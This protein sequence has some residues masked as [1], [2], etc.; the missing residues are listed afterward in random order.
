MLASRLCLAALCSA[1]TVASEARAD[2]EGDLVMKREG[3]HG[4]RMPTGKIRFKDGKL[5]TEIAMGPMN[6]TTLVDFAARKVL[7]INSAAKEYSEMDADKS[8]RANFPKCESK[9][10]QACLADQGFKKS[11][12]ETVNGQACTIWE[13]DRKTRRGTLHEKLWHPDAAGKEFAFVRQV[14]DGEHGKSEL[15]VENFKLAEQDAALFQVP[16]D[17]KKSEG[18]FPGMQMGPPSMRGFKPKPGGPTGGE[19]K[20][21]DE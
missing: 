4:K 15:D 7:M 8:G 2:W 12:T 10:F 14:N 5:R 17:Y 21:K 1:L 3:S 16:E 6:M 9:D 18:M 11:G 19:M 13:G 20:E